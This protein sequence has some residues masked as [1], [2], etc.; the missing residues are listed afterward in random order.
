MTLAARQQAKLEMLGKLRDSIKP[1]MS[2]KELTS[3]IINFED[4]CFNPAE[5]LKAA[6]E[7]YLREES[8]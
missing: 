5:D 6:L 8:K 3:T 1:E 4:W 7:L 2:V